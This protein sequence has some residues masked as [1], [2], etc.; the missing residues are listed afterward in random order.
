MV[1]QMAYRGPQGVGMKRWWLIKLRIRRSLV[2]LRAYFRPHWRELACPRC[3]MIV[4]A[5]SGPHMTEAVGRHG[6]EI[7]S[8]ERARDIA[9]SLNKMGISAADFAESCKRFGRAG[10][11]LKELAGNLRQACHRCG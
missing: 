11:G 10:I 9:V 1:T 6:R 4:R 8:N 7:H 3:G 2:K 5:R